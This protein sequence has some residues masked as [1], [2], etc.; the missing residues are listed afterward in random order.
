MSNIVEEELFSLGRIVITI[1]A[2]NLLN[3]LN[4][5]SKQFLDRY[6]NGDW[7]D[8][9]QVDKDQNNR[10]L[11]YGHFILASYIVTDDDYRQIWIKT[12][13]DRSITTIMLP[14]DW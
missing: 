11:K 4:I 7:G 9:P 14:T 8:I 3:A 6:R 1:E 5:D 13:W 2:Q 12:E 10:S